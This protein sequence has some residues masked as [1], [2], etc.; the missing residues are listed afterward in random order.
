MEPGDV[1]LLKAD[2]SSYIEG[3]SPDN[4]LV[5]NAWTADKAKDG[6]ISYIRVSFHPTSTLAAVETSG[7]GREF[8]TQ[9]T[10]EVG[11]VSEDKW[12][13]LSTDGLTLPLKEPSSFDELLETEPNPE[14]VC[15]S[16]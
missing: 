13:R 7:Y 11:S 1:D 3:R 4:V 2:A 6:A 16:V 14:E 12:W 10:L 9:Y 15:I 5:G 8:V